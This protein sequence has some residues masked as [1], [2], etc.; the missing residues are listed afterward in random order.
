TATVKGASTAGAGPGSAPAGAGG[1]T[2]APGTAPRSAPATAACS[3]SRSPITIGTVGQQSGV[4]GSIYIAGARTVQTWTAAVNAA[5]GLHC[6][7]VR[8]LIEDDGGDPSRHQALVHKLVEADHVLAFVFM[9][10]PLTGN[11]SQRYITDQRIP[12]I[13]TELGSDFF[14]TSPMYFP[15]ATGGNPIVIAIIAQAA[16]V[17]RTAG[18]TRLGNLTCLEAPVCARMYEMA[19][20][21]SKFGVTNVYRA[22][23]SLAQ[24]DYTSQCQAAESAGVQVLVVTLDA[25]SV[26]RLLRSC[27]TVNFHPILAVTA[28]AIPEA[29][30]ALDGVTLQHSEYPWFLTNNPAVVEYQSVIRKFSPGLR[31]S[32]TGLSGWVSAKLFELAA[33]HLSEPPASD[34]LLEGLWTIRDNDMGGLTQPLTFDRDRNAPRVVCYWGVKIEGG[35]FVSTDGGKRTCLGTFTD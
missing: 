6:H 2:S 29:D 10:A 13:G 8:Y 14:Y 35:D 20:R 9:D 11:A 22:Q 19:D 21:A 16:D 1:A 31:P 27:N 7:P 30:A 32:A 4:L 5:G 23:A 15:Q 33:E 3:G 28:T 34:S 24:P 26:K 12:V 18:K 25:N 17:A